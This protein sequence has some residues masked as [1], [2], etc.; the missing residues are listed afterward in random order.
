MDIKGLY[1][2]IKDQNFECDRIISNSATPRV[3]VDQTKNV[4]YNHRKEIEEA[5][6]FA[7]EAE[8]KSKLLE[9]E[10]DDYEAENKELREK[11][12]AQEGKATKPKKA[13]GEKVG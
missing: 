8:E 11:L 10:L 12:K 9:M 1:E 7:V 4:F 6:K 2:R 5:L 3:A 13:S